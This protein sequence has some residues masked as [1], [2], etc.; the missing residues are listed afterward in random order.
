MSI[1][2]FLIYIMNLLQIYSTNRY[3]VFIVD[4][5]Y[6]AYIEEGDTLIE[7]GTVGIELV[8]VEYK[9]YSWVKVTK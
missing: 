2:N 8:E 1:I 6:Y 7:E 5:R 4:G 3:F 9:D